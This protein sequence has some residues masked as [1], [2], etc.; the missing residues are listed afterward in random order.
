MFLTTGRQSSKAEQSVK[1]MPAPTPSLLL[2][3]F[4]TL[5]VRCPWGWPH[6]SAA[7]PL[8]QVLGGLAHS[9][10][11]SV[12]IALALFKHAE[13]LYHNRHCALRPAAPVGWAEVQALGLSLVHFSELRSQVLTNLSPGSAD[14]QVTAC[15]PGSR[16][17]SGTVLLVSE[18]LFQ[19]EPRPGMQVTSYKGSNKSYSSIT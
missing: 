4:W 11:E 5:V 10:P 7:N 12:T 9:G 19:I 14:A 2:C 15:L 16:S 8:K 17:R 1:S 13:T 18:H 3:L 6:G